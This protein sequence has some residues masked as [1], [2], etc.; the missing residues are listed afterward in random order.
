MKGIMS[1]PTSESPM[2]HSAKPMNIWMIVSI[3]L[4]VI[5]LGLIAVLFTKGG[6]MTGGVSSSQASERLMSFVNEVYGPRIGQSQI[7]S[8]T[9]EHGMYKVVITVNNQGQASDE[10]VFLTKDAK[11]FVTQSLDIDQALAAYRAQAA[12]GTQPT[13]G[14]QAPVVPAPTSTSTATGTPAQ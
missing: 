6:S 14:Q 3:V 11:I 9:E 12:G 13:D 10:T 7:K 1:T 2:N 5:V 8:I 4:A